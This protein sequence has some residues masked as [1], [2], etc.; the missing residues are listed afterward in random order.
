MLEL[1]KTTQ[2]TLFYF[3]FNFF[4]LFPRAVFR[5]FTVKPEIEGLRAESQEL[6]TSHSTKQTRSITNNFLIIK[7]LY[8]H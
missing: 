6:K 4:K 3:F 1:N 2:S 7:G 8:H 5:I